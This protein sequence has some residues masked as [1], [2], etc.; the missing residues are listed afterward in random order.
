MRRLFGRPPCHGKLLSMA[1][2]RTPLVQRR[3]V[4]YVRT[5]TA[6]CTGGIAAMRVCGSAAQRM[7]IA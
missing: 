3:Y 5:A 6:M 7:C 1:I 4:D 2:A